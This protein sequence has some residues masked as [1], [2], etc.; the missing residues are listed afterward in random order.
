MWLTFEI[1]LPKEIYSKTIVIIFIFVGVVLITILL[2]SFFCRFWIRRS[3]YEESTI[4]NLKSKESFHK[5]YTSKRWVDDQQ[6]LKYKRNNQGDLLYFVR[7]N[8]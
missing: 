6:A 3:N 4:E 5:A 1:I 2:A 7:N 8:R